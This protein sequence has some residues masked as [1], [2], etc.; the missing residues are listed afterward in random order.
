[1][2]YHVKVIQVYP[3][4]FHDWEMRPKYRVDVTD[5][6]GKFVGYEFAYT[7]WGC[8]YMARKAINK[9]TPFGTS[10]VEEYD[11]EL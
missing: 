4:I 10:V 5:S 2:K 11:V 1:M 7:K 9:A 3:K 8:K 6:K